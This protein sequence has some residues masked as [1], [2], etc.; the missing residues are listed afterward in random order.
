[1]PTV[2][3]AVRSIAADDPTLVAMLGDGVNSIFPKGGAKPPGKAPWIEL[4]LFGESDLDGIVASL[5]FRWRVYDDQLQ[6]F[7]RIDNIIGRLRKLYKN[8]DRVLYDD[9]SGKTFKQ[10]WTF[11][12]ADAFDDGFSHHVRWVE[13]QIWRGEP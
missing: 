13:W 6:A 11:T 7:S 5:G 9:P 3:T 10:R 1:M 8:T 4:Q 2:R 12:S